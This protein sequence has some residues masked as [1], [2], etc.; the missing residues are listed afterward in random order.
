VKRDWFATRVGPRV[1][2]GLH[3]G[4][5]LVLPAYTALELRR[6]EPYPLDYFGELVGGPSGVARS[7]AFELAWWGE[8]FRDA[9]EYVNRNAPPGGRVQLALTPDDTAP[10]L[11]GDLLAV[12]S[13]PGDFVVTNHY[14]FQPLHPRG[15]TRVHTVRVVGA[16][17]VDV[18]R[19][20]PVP[21]A[22]RLPQPL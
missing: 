10:K 12:T 8:G 4:L 19:C 16:P 5:A 2:S 3:L 15:C 18:Y 11:R 1:R 20:P 13:P 7:H 9:I 6:V 22:V 14:K 21:R 17:L